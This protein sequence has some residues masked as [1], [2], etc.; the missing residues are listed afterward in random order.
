M[1]SKNK[2]IQSEKRL[3]GL[4]FLLIL[5]ISACAV[6]PQDKTSYHLT[7]IGTADLQGALEPDSTA[8]N[9]DA[10][11]ETS[12]IVG[13][14]A[15]L[16]TMIKTVK[17]ETGGPVAVVSSG[18]DLM[19]RYFHTFKGKAIFQLMSEAGYEIYAF[20]NHEFD[21]G[22]QVLAE[23]LRKTQWQS[24]CTDLNVENTPLEDLCR[25]WL[26]KDYNGLKVGFFSLMT[27]NFPLV[28]SGREV[29]LARQNIAAAQWAVSQLQAR[30]VQ[31]IVALTHIGFKQDQRLAQ[32]VEGIDIIFGGHSHDYIPKMARVGQTI[33]VNGGEKGAYLVR[34]D[35]T[36]NAYGAF[37]RDGVRYALLPVTAAVSPDK[38]IE[39]RLKE[40]Q[41]S[42]PAEIVLGHTETA[43]NLTKGA[44]RR[45]E[46]AVCNLVNDL[47]RAKFNADI[48]LNNAGAFRGGKKYPPGPVT[49]KML[50]EIDEFSN[51]AYMLDI[52]GR[53][54][55][56]I[57]ERSAASFDEGGFLHPAGIR[58][59]VDLRLTAQ[60]IDHNAS[61][62]LN[63]TRTG[64]RVHAIRILNANGQWQPLEADKIYRVLSNSY[65]VNQQGDGYFWFKR[66]GRNLENTYSTFYSILAEFIGNKGVLNP[67]KSD[68]RITV[69]IGSNLE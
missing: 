5:I 14:I 3:P 52:E 12:P 30:D 66:Y 48:V 60:K 36:F 6:T 34:L 38:E 26:I 54:L 32:T 69:K 1:D 44:L 2:K 27:E 7:I 10:D 21:K 64:N 43:W 9:Q 19:N 23:A 45:G 59:T 31:I 37:D 8:P 68:Q 35:L 62:E 39:E 47:M 58:Y 50:K 67:G 41:N 20:G 51:Y 33:V 65:L 53:H 22:P 61:K 15:R 46:A 56:A 55:K 4:L 42:F 24:V 40:Y 57:L 49:D 11:S 63:V 16:A 25:P 18:D 28:T 13:G 29:T 17:A